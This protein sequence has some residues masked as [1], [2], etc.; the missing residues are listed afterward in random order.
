MS[1][2]TLFG[3]LRDENEPVRGKGQFA[4]PVVRGHNSIY[5]LEKEPYIEASLGI[6]NICKIL[7]IDYIRRLT[8]T[9]HKDI[10]KSGIRFRFKF[11]F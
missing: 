6:G 3:G 4:F 7:R 8:Y 11:D 9:D 5:S 2:K 10:A 1:F